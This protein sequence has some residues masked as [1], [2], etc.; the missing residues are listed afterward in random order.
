MQQ[1]LLF[2]GKRYDVKMLAKLA[3]FSRIEEVDTKLVVQ[4]SERTIGDKPL[5]VQ[6]DGTYHVLVG[7]FNPTESKAKLSVISKVI[8]KKAQIEDVQPVQ[9]LSS[10]NKPTPRSQSWG[11]QRHDYSDEH[12]YDGRY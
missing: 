4:H 9:T 8:L 1:V 11:R 10:R 3:A 6:V 7:T 2:R 5:A 12:E